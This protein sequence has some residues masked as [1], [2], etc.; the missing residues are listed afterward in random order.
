M[1]TLAL[2]KKDIENGINIK[3]KL[4]IDICNSLFLKGYTVSQIARATG[5]SPSAV[6]KYV[7]RHKEDIVYDYRDRGNLLTVKADR[8]VNRSLD[9]INKI[10]SSTND[11][12]KKDLSSLSV[13]TGILFDKL[14]ILQGLSTQ[15]ISLAIAQSNVKEAQDTISNAKT[16]LKELES[17]CST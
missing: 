4:T 17:N 12:G 3:T 1:N 8:I 7:S 5:N 10:L 11:F 6:S 9:A 13:T 2:V 16:R 14:R 15:N